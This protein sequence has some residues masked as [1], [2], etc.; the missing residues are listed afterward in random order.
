V[1]LLVYILNT[2]NYAVSVTQNVFEMIFKN[3][4][5]PHSRVFLQMLT[6]SRLIKKVHYCSQCSTICPKPETQLAH[7]LQV[8]FILQWRNSHGGSSPFHYRGFI[9]I[10]RHITVG[11]THL[12]E[13][14]ALRT[15]LYRKT[16]NTYKRHQCLRWDL[17]PQSQQASGR[18]PTP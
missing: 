9:I 6:G 13:W 8:Y 17:N 2:R 12:D 16:H 7:D 10:L 14:S 4:L 3:K 18:R 5:Y 15:D 1:Y 11:R